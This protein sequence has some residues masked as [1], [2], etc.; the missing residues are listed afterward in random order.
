LIDSKNP[1][2]ALRLPPVIV[3]DPSGM[4]ILLLFAAMLKYLDA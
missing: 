2:V 3:F 1:V 4:K